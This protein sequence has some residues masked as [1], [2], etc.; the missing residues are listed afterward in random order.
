MDLIRI[1]DK[2][3]HLR[4]RNV[5]LDIDLAP[6]YGMNT[7]QVKNMVLRNSQRFPEDC[8]FILTHAEWL[9]MRKILLHMNIRTHPFPKQPP[10]AFTDMGLIMLAGLLGS[11]RAIEMNIA[12]VRSFVILHA[13][14]GGNV[15]L[16]HL[17]KYD[18]LQETM[19]ALIATP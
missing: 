3:F 19:Q 12:I 10:Q 17:M 11:S 7:R 16:R 1:R 15:S 2:I 18:E 6:L 4:G 5:I 13:S 8:S 9:P 14:S